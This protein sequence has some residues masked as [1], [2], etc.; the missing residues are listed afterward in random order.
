MFR[1]IR[2]LSPAIGVQF[3]R[4]MVHEFNVLVSIRS[5]STR[6]DNAGGTAEAGASQNLKST[7]DKAADGDPKSSECPAEGA[8]KKSPHA[9][10]E[11]TTKNAR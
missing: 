6:D 11:R 5:L 2:H 7:P 1:A 3:Y 4:P 8:L 9:I 10:L